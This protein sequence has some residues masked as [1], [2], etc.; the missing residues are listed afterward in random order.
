MKHRFSLAALLRPLALVVGLLTL[1]LAVG[2]T[3]YVSSFDG[4]PTAGNADAMAS[5]LPV[6]PPTANASA[7]EASA[8]A[9]PAPSRLGARID[10]LLASR[11]AESAFWGV[12][13]QDLQTGRLI[14]EHNAD[15]S[16]LPASNQKLVTSAAAL[17]LLGGTY[18]YETTLE[19]DGT[20]ENDLM[21][22]DLVIVGSG[23]PT[24]G[25][26]RIRGKDPL[27]EWAERLASMGVK[28]VEGRL[29]GNDNAFD[30]RP[31]AKGWDVDY[32]T[33]QASRYMGVVPSG[34]AYNDNV[35]GLSIYAT[36]PGRRPSVRTYPDNVVTVNN[37]ATTSG[38][39]RGNAIQIDR[40]FTGNDIRLSGSIPRTYKGSVDLPVSN[41]TML[42][43][44]SFEQFL[45]EE[46]IETDLTVADIDDVDQKPNRS[47]D[48]LFVYLSPPLSEILAVL[49]KESDNFYAE[50]LFR[51]Y[52]WAG[53]S[54]GA[55]RRTKRFLR[56]AGADTRELL[57]NDGSGLSRKDLITPRA[58]TQMLSYMDQHP[59][60]DTY[61]ASLPA[62]G[63]NE[64]TLERRLHR[65][66]V[67]AKT[68]SL[69][70]VRALSGYITRGDGSRVSFALFANNYTGPS[71]RI[72]HTMDEI[73]REIAASESLSPPQ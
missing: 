37:E 70:F 10:E 31:Y 26:S 71:Y 46:G 50:Q 22:G 35:I 69:R 48:A 8:S 29:I 45:Q 18:R 63:E 6:V 59:A 23:D 57:I 54:E 47:A 40:S 20:I 51:T 15:K 43:L 64:T 9:A 44:R 66:P 27:K 7:A 11:K 61:F 36:A 56:Q 52:G 72:S 13:I 14:Y 30:D 49:N 38:R 39:R 60:R 24:F 3:V 67:Q 17:D 5:P 73:V 16:F 62:G 25:S 68:G 28:R 21:K 32:L 53:S 33:H 65:V 42:A 55:I 58:M 34:L 4:Q 2:G 1:T 12:S 19:F 41:P